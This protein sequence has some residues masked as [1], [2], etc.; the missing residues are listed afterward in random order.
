MLIDEQG[1][2]HTPLTDTGKLTLFMV[3]YD[4]PSGEYRV[5]L[6]GLDTGLQL[7][8]ENFDWNFSLPEVMTPVEANFSNEVHLIGYDLTNRRVK[9]G[10][11]IPLVL[12]WQSLR[13]MLNSYII[14]DRL[15]ASDNQVWGGY[16]R[17]P[18]ETYPTN[19]WVPGEVV[20]DGFAVPVDPDTPPGVYDVVLGLYNE[21]DPQARSL[22]IYRDGQATEQTSIRIGPIKVD[23][24]PSEVVLSEDEPAPAN[25]LSVEFG[26]PPVIMLRGYDLAQTDEA[27]QVQ[28]YW[29][30]LA[31][32]PIN[33]TTFVHLRNAAGETVAQ[34]DS[35]PAGGKYPTSLWDAGEMIPDSLQVSIPT[36]LPSGRYDIVAGMY[37][38]ATGERLPIAENTNSSVVLL[39]IEIQ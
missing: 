37:D 13:R 10:G 1:Q 4:W 35:P 36:E 14:F 38:L 17:L 34:I 15:L 8:V 31:Q 11:G 32:T 26:D 2:S 27:I 16:D 29:Q 30:S 12:Y 5:Q 25:S 28:L 39:T 22:P 23:G 3:D 6:G 19:L 33:W 20:I 24:P 18:K 21:A 7:R 9:A